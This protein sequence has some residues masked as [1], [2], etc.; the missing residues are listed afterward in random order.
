MSY[1]ERICRH[2]DPDHFSRVL[3]LV[4]YQNLTMFVC[5]HVYLHMHGCVYMCVFVC[6]HTCIG[7]IFPLMFFSM[8]IR[9]FAIVIL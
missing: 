6:M 2:Q 1:K 4:P 3:G 7:N 5:V 9:V 8:L